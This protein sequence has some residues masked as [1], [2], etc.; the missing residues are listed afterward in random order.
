[1]LILIGSDGNNLDSLV[2][3]RFGHS[4]Y[5]ILYDTESKQFEAVKNEEEHKHN[6][7]N[8]VDFINKGTEI[9]IVGNIGPHAFETIKSFEKRIF[10]ARKLTVGEAI[11]KYLNGELIELFEPT[12]K[13]SIG[14]KHH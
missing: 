5:F 6:H 4:N 14:H 7:R 11:N 2:S 13:K 12:A 10:L 3:K 9:F 8:I 1:M